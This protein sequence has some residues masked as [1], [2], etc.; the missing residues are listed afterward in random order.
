[1]LGAPGSG[2][3]KMAKKISQERNLKILD[4]LPQK[5]VKKTD[6]ALGQFSDYRTDFIFAGDV[7][8]KEYKYEK[9]DY[10]ITAGP[11]YTYCHFAYKATLIEDTEKKFDILWHMMAM[12]RIALDS[13]WY[14]KIYYLPY[15]KE[16]DTFSFYMDRC[17]KNAIKEFY[18]KEKIITID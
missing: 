17:I 11:L 7:L 14:D 5:F 18:L 1:M 8:L 6:L 10:I 13:L 12:G 9:E 2:K 4:R 15:K 3:S 16:E